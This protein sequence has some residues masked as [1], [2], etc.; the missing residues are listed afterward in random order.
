MAKHN[1]LGARGE[2][3]A[4]RYLQRAGYRVLDR[5]WRGPTGE[6]DLVVCRGS[7]LVV[8]EV[9]TRRTR[10][11]GDPLAAVDDRKLERVWRSAL[12]WARAHPSVSRGRDLRVD[13]IGITMDEADISHLRDV[14]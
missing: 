14:R 8:V 1:E 2:A 13:V 12:A 6:V 9:K 4:A 11:F 3:E 10:A 7:A 5:N